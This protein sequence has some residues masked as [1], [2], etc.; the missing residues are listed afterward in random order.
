MAASEEAILGIPFYSAAV[1]KQETVPKGFK[2][3][4]HV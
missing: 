3:Q 1:N 2:P 4:P